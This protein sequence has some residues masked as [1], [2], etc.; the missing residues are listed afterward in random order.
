MMLVINIYLMLCHHCEYPA[1]HNEII[2]GS[3]IQR[4]VTAPSVFGQKKQLHAGILIQP[5]FHRMHIVALSCSNNTNNYSTNF[6]YKIYTNYLVLIYL[7]V[8]K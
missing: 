3:C 6:R 4:R 2:S 7:A 8:N 1:A 5:N